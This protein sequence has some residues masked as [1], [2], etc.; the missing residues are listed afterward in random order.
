MSVVR[1]R[2]G[3]SLAEPI[4][5]ESTGPGGRD[6]RCREQQRLLV[7]PFEDGDGAG[8]RFDDHPRV[9]AVL[10]FDALGAGLVDGTLPLLPA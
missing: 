3:P 8:D 5:G 7:Q 10:A 6:D 9:G 4:L 1:H 2:V